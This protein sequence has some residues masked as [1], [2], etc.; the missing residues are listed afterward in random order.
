MWKYSYPFE[1][2][3]RRLQRH[4]AKQTRVAAY[5]L[6]L[7]PQTAVY[8]V[9]KIGLRITSCEKAQQCPDISITE[10]HRLHEDKNVVVTA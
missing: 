6:G 5:D 4:Q 7:W 1:I 9:Q 3:Y 10:I 8:L 2:S